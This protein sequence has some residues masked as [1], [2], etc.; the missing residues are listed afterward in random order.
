MKRPPHFGIRSLAIGLVGI[1]ILAMFA[2]LALAQPPASPTPDAAVPAES[3]ETVGL[4]SGF[5]L[6][7][8]ICMG[9]SIAALF[10]A[11]RFFQW[12][13]ASDAGTPRMIEIAGYVKEGANAYLRQQ[14]KVVGLFFVVI[15]ILLAI[16][17]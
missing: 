2:G 7:W 9:A 16:M 6:A 4:F 5:G 3:S 11:Y 17:V 8:L 15:F 13:K 10:Q 1:A 12:M 14:Y